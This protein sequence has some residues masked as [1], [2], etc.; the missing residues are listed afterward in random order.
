MGASPTQEAVG[1]DSAEG[2]GLTKECL[3]LGVSLAS[4]KGGTFLN[5]K[6]TMHVYSRLMGLGA[7]VGLLGRQNGVALDL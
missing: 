2:Q 1:G 3:E 6:A 4:K 7:S 5:P